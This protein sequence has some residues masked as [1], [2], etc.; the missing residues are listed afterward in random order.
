LLI[1][2]RTGT[3][4]TLRGREYIG[5]ETEAGR[6]ELLAAHADKLTLS[7]KTRFPAGLLFFTGQC[8]DL[9]L[10]VCSSS[11]DSADI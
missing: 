7:F 1:S 9:S 4:V 8:R 2:V 11:R 5:W 10:R 6:A 3:E